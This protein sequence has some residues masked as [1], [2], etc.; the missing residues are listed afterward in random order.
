MQ[1]NRVIEAFEVFEDGGTG[2]LPRLETNPIRTF[3]RE[4]GKKCLHRRIVPTVG[5]PTHTDLASQ[6]GQQRLIA[7]GGKFRPT[8]RM[9]QQASCWMPSCHRHAQRQF[10]EM[11]IFGGSHGL[12]NHHP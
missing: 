1:T 7:L 4:R 5:G 11:A 10:S 9:M 3:L 2:L 12:A 6:L 8:I